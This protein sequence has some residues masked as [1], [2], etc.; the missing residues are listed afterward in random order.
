MVEIRGLFFVSVPNVAPPS[1][2]SVFG[3]NNAG[4]GAVKAGDRI[5]NAF[6][7]LAFGEAPLSPNVDLVP[8]PDNSNHFD[9]VAPSDGTVVYVGGPGG[10]QPGTYL[11]LVQKGA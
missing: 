2:V 9:P 5:L 7:L 11:L 1:V 6:R 8:W 4:I 10:L 3:L